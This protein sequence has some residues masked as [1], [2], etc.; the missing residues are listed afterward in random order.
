MKKFKLFKMLAVLIVLITSI[1]TAYADLYLIGSMNNWNADNWDSKWKFVTNKL[2]VELDANTNYYIR[3]KD[4]YT[5][6]YFN[7]GVSGTILDYNMDCTGESGYIY[8]TTAEAGVYTF[9][10]QWTGSQHHISIYYPRARLKPGTIIYFDATSSNTNKWRDAAFHA[11]YLYKNFDTGTNI[12][13][14]AVQWSESPVE[15]WVHYTT[16]PNNDYIGQVQICRMNPSDHSKEW[17]Y[18]G[19]ALARERSDDKQNCMIFKSAHAGYDN[20]QQFDWKTY[21]PPMS[22]ASLSDNSTSVISWTS[23]DGTSGNPY[24][25]PATGTIKV[26]ASATSAVNDANMTKKYN[27]KVSDNGASATSNEVTEPTYTY[28]KTSLVND[29]TYEIS[30]EAWNNYNSTDGTK[31]TTATHKWYKALTM[32]SVNHTMTNV[33]K[34]EGRAGDD[35]AAYHLPYSAI[36][37]AKDGYILP[38]S[39]IVKFGSTQKTANTDYTWDSSTG[40]LNILADKIDGNVTVIISGTPRWYISGSSEAMGEWAFPGTNAIENYT[41][42]A[43][44]TKGYVDITLAARTEYEFKMYDLGAGSEKWVGYASEMASS[45]NYSNFGTAYALN[46][47]PG[48]NF[49]FRSAGAGTYRFTRDITNNTVTI[50]CSTAYL[51]TY[52]GNDK[53]GGSVPNAD[54]Y[55]SGETVTVA[56]KGDLAKTNYDF[57]GWNT[58]NDGSGDNYVAE[59]GTFTINS[60]TNLYAKWT[61]TVIL[62]KN[63][64]NSEYR[65]DGSLTATYN[66]DGSFTITTAPVRVGYSVE[67]YY[68]EPECTNKVMT[69]AGA[70]VNYTGYVEGGKWVHA[71]ATILYTKWTQDN[72]VIYRSGDMDGESRTTSDAVYSY[73]GG[74]I[75]KPIEYRMKVSEL[76][77]WYT[78]CLPFEVNA[79]KVWGGT[80]YLSIYPCHR[81]SKGETLRQGYYVIRTPDSEEKSGSSVQIELN[82]F[83]DWVDPFYYDGYVPSAN[84]PYIIQWNMSYFDGKYISFFGAAGQ[85]IP[86]AM[87]GVE[88]PTDE[89]IKICGNNSMTNGTVAGVY[90]L[91]NDYGAGAW[92][93][94]EDV[95]EKRT[96]LPFECYLIASESTTA[97]NMVIKRR[98]GEDSA[99]GWEEILNYER[100]DVITVYTITGYKVAQYENCSF[101]EAG[102]RM[103]GEL[104]E[105][106]YIMNAGNESVKLIIR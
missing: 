51:L 64:T 25:V 57:C 61:Q 4:G 36:Y 35:A 92:L 11:K 71:G 15:T 30:L 78:L 33:T 62:D 46:T 37:E 8:L 39:I 89:Y 85:T 76:N 55:G 82:N 87:S 70:L 90:L 5:D 53:T 42:S 67:G 74:T 77:K 32:Y 17:N 99:T 23:G 95:E 69:E 44:V 12:S 3:I 28:N 93:R 48:Y 41:T 94:A 19:N 66:K 2:E 100:K 81:P 16:V 21:C 88:A 7:G 75:S 9:H 72:F 20:T 80:E 22:A 101:D 38:S 105:G 91:D 26:S 6:R 52:Y 24:L 83:G 1:N 31:H 98:T 49:K 13:S 14:D 96:I 103:N 27:F 65:S 47:Y 97:N 34:R 106:I 79:V 86:A 40:V 10:Y 58:E 104:S 102:R 54:Y 18:S 63:G 60:N 29:H 45:I 59:T 43:G 84:T 68:A 56:A 73:A 50:T